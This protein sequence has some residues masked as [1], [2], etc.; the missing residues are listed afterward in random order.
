MFH[1]E[2]Q[3]KKKITMWL[4]LIAAM[5]FFMVFVGGV[6]RLT[7]SGLSMV[8]WKP[9]TG[10]IPPLSEAHWE[11]EFLKY[12]NFPEFKLINHQMTLDEFKEIYFWEYFHRV[13]GRLIGMAFFFPYLYF[14][15]KK[16]IPKGFNKK[17]IFTFVLGG[18]QGAMGWYMVKSGLVDKPDVSHY[19]LAAHL[20]LAF[21]IIG[22]IS[23][24]ILELNEGV[25]KGTRNKMYY[26]SI[27]LILLLTLQITYGAFVAGLNAGIGY[28]TFPLMNGHFVPETFWDLSP[29]WHNFI[30][31]KASIQFVHRVIAWFVLLYITTYT[32]IF[33]KKSTKIQKLS[34]K[35]LVGGVLVQF[36][37]GVLTLLY[38]VPISLASLHQLGALVLLLF[39]IFNLH[40]SREKIV[41]NQ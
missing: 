4:L 3:D 36:T 40:V 38:F 39:G 29:Y 20:L 31:N 6:T 8:E 28:N 41:A 35:C 18:L 9:V 7:N 27:G 34:F 32:F 1:F 12:Q 21:L 5:V 25:H 13:I 15:L 16:K 17:L 11:E 33:Y 37:L 2:S 30:E 23:K 14:L 24:L 19:R 10:I 26:A 22:Y